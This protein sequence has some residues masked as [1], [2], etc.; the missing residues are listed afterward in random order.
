MSEQ[1]DSAYSS[2]L[3]IDPGTLNAVSGAPLTS[4]GKPEVLYVASEPA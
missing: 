3:L 1:D 2:T 4:S